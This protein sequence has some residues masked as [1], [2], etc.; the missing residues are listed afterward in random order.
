VKDV[1]LRLISELIKSSRRSDRELAKVLGVSQPT[2]SRMRVR[3]EKERLLEYTA[4]PDLAKLGLEILAVTIG[5]RDYPKPSEIALQEAKDF[6]KKHP[7]IIFASAGMG[8]GSDR[9][10]ISVHKDYS[11]YVK[12]RGELNREVEGFVITD[13]FLISLTGK[14][15]LRPLSFRYIVDYLKKEK[16]LE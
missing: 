5:K 12:L 13:A 14:D 1:E 8:I 3:L 6:T 4:I 2:V 10:A 7:N 9:M 11:D 16:E 15:V